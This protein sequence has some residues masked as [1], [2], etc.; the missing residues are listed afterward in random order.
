[1]SLRLGRYETLRTIASGGM[2]MVHL[3]RALGAGGFERFVAIKVMHPHLA[4]DPDFVAMF[5]DEARLAARVRHPNV[6]A[7]IDVQEDPLFL[8]MEYIEGPSLFEIMR[9]MFKARAR[10]PLSVTLRIFVDTLAGLHAAHDLM[11]ADG[12]PLLLVHRDV[13]PQNVLVGTDG[14]TRITDFGVARAESRLSTTRGGQLKGKIAY[15]A[16]EQI[17]SEPVDR[18]SD[19]YAA[20]V[21]LWE[22]LTGHRLF[23]GD[24]DGALV[25]QVLSGVK[26]SPRE[27]CPAVPEAIDRAC[28]RALR[29]GLTDRYSTAGDFSDALEDAAREAGVNVASPRVV[30]TFIKELAVHKGLEDW[31]AP[32]PSQ[33]GAGSS[34][35]SLRGANTPESSAGGADSSPRSTPSNAQIAPPAGPPAGVASSKETVRPGAPRP[36]LD[37]VTLTAPVVEV[38]PP[39]SAAGSDVG[40][41]ASGSTNVAAVVSMGQRPR[42]ILRGRGLLITA[43]LAIAGAGAFFVLTQR[44]TVSSALRNS[45]G[46]ETTSSV[47]SPQSTDAPPAPLTGSTSSAA[48]PSPS[49]SADDGGPPPGSSTSA[50]MGAPGGTVK[51]KA[52]PAAGAKGPTGRP[53]T[54]SGS[55]TAPSPTSFRPPDL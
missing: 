20:G 37:E 11:G 5:L 54:P 31:P 42:T 6:V 23:R 16:P 35:R 22:M 55:K 19:L 18:R 43:A 49:S 12:A 46:P 32:P 30:A 33:P 29:N 1:M 38:P 47:E 50:A 27:I 45:A 52:H 41:S 40:A 26:R 53:S 8:V 21:V 10:V 17:L 34:P 7:T 14:I 24:N 3:G 28:M 51:V 25:A 48:A 36:P 39:S 9:Q 2:A 4:T 15:M 44:N 13:S